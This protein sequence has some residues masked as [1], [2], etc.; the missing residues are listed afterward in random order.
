MVGEWMFKAQGERGQKAARLELARLKVVLELLEAASSNLF[1]AGAVE[2]GTMSHT[3]EI[4]WW[5]TVQQAGLTAV[6]IEVQ[7][8]LKL[9]QDWLEGQGY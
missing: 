3:E 8:R 6:R 1:E 5:Y 9:L 7:K 2:V 4:T